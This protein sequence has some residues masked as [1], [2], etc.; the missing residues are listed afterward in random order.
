MHV[1]FQTGDIIATDIQQTTVTVCWTVP[2][3]TEQQQYTVTY[4]TDPADL[5]QMSGTVTGNADVTLTDQQY[6]VT[7]SGLQQSTLY[8][9]K[10]NI[11]FG[12][13]TIMTELSTFRTLEDR[14]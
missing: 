9:F 10:I 11:T 4:G 14:K 3:V 5:N 1:C 8:H 7:L 6:C 13:L 12:G 2:S